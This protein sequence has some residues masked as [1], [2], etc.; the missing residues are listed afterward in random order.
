VDR[1]EVRSEVLLRQARG[2]P[3]QIAGIG[4]AG[5]PG[6][7]RALVE[8]GSQALPVLREDRLDPEEQVEAADGLDPDRKSVV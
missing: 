4:H 2:D 6:R 5:V 1:E 3:D 8:E 7:D